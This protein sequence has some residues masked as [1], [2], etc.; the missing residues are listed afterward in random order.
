MDLTIIDIG[1]AENIFVGDEAIIFGKDKPVES[2]AEVCQTIPYEI[3]SRI[4]SRVRRLYV[5]G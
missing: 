1:E 5:Q 2:L 4:S 3:L